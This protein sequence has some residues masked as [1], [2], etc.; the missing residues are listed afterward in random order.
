MQKFTNLTPN[1]Q[2]TQEYF[3]QNQLEF[4][5]CK[6][7]LDYRICLFDKLCWSSCIQLST[8]RV[9]LTVIVLSQGSGHL[10]KIW[11][12][13]AKFAFDQLINKSNVLKIIWVN[14]WLVLCQIKD[15]TYLKKHKNVDFIFELNID[16]S[17]FGW[18]QKLDLE[19]NIVG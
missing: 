14:F 10:G 19:L 18:A 6:T 1:P 15:K 3:L 16:G 5:N 4:Q 8:I 7:K 9:N 13:E 17:A 2:S 12:L 11:C